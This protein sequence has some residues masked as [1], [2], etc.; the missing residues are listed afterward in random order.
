MKDILVFAILASLFS[1]CVSE[2]DSK[3]DE[4]GLNLIFEVVGCAETG[5]GTAVRGKSVFEEKE[6]VIDYRD[7]Q[8]IYERT[9]R[10]LCCRKAEVIH[11][12]RQ[13][14]DE[15]ELSLFEMWS[16]RGCRCMCQSHIMAALEGME[17]GRYD[18][19]VMVTGVNPDGTPMTEQGI[20]Q[21][22]VFV[23]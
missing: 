23:K 22:K 16:G 2:D 5:E 8:I 9:L 11:K 3:S 21:K 7:G 14:Y 1:G 15:K 18:V 13:G 19:R 17:P 6:P 12:V 20:V 10:H 4:D